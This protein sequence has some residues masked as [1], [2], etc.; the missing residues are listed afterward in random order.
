[1]GV[2]LGGPNFSPVIVE[3]KCK[4][5]LWNGC[6]SPYAPRWGNLEEGLLYRGIR[7]TD[8]RRFWRGASLFMGL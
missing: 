4:R 5:R 1:M 6:L 8:E 7:E 3:E 2:Q